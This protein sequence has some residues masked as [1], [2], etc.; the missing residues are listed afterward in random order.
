MSA[1]TCNHPVWPNGISTSSSRFSRPISFPNRRSHLGLINSHGNKHRHT[2]NLLFSACCFPVIDILCMYLCIYAGRRSSHSISAKA[3]LSS[4]S[5][6]PSPSPW[7]DKP[8]EMLRGGRK[9]Y[10][11]EQDVVAFLDPPKDLVPLD[12][13]SFN[14]A[15]YL[16]YEAGKT[17][18]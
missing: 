6:S 14:P 4:S 3:L 7:D 1:A 8:Y 15:A 11:D 13:A 12:P 9:V 16:W 2:S 18:I 10:L 5:P 17:Q